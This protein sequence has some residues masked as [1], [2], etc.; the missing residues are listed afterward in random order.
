MKGG[1][2]G[3]C[4]DRLPPVRWAR[5]LARI[6]PARAHVVTS[7]SVRHSR[8]QQPNGSSQQRE[9]KKEKDFGKEN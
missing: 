2:G 8:H 4:A 7:V 6:R 3:E 9:R 1:T 5:R